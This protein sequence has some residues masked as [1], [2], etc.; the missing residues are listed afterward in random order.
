MAVAAERGLTP[1]VGRD[2]E[3]AQLDACFQRLVAN[4]Q[5]NACREEG[6]QVAVAKGQ[7]RVPK[8]R[9]DVALPAD[10][11]LGQDLVLVELQA[12]G[13]QREHDQPRQQSEQEQP[14]QPLLVR[15]AESEP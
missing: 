10:D 9:N 7:C 15:R 1:L 11:V 13:R 4:H 12:V 5:V 2:E 3:L 8:P 6:V 14:Q